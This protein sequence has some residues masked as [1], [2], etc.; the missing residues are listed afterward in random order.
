MY[1]FSILIIISIFTSCNNKT[2]IG[3]DNGIHY[4]SSVYNEITRAYIVPWKIGLNRETEASMGVRFFSTIPYLSS[5]AKETLLN[6][7]GI[8]SW[9]I[10]FT[11]MRR[12]KPVPMGYFFIKFG[13]I[14]RNTK[15]ISV[16]LFYQAAS[17]SKRFRFFH[18]PAFGHRLKVQSFEVKYRNES[19]SSNIY[20]RS[21]EKIRAKVT[22]FK[23]SPMILPAGRK[24]VGDYYIDLAFYSSHSKQRF[25]K[26]HAVD[27]VLRIHQEIA[28]IVTSCVG[29]KEEYKT[30]PKSRLPDIRDFQ[31]PH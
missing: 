16:S 3:L 5:D 21:T 25:S 26:W 19:S 24:L 30:L 11:R 4:A 22:R 31:I 20:V 2:E 27:G 15:N 17:V 7:Y 13:N 18:Y 8:D 10:R 6:K 12:N 1:K 28:K 14:T 23:F 9:V 29:I